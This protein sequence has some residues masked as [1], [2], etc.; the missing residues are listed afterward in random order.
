MGEVLIHSR[1]R[2]GPRKPNATTPEDLFA[3]YCGVTVKATI[4]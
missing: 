4:K 2:G 1:R 3:G